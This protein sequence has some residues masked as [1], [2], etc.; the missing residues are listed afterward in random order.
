MARLFLFVI[1]AII[2]GVIA[3]IKN[4]VG[5]V[6]GNEKLKDASVKSEAKKIIG[7]RPPKALG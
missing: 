2:A 7:D 1:I 5:E 4:A 3:L 6:S